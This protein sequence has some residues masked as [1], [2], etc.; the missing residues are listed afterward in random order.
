MVPIR[1]YIVGS[2]VTGKKEPRDLD[3]MAVMKN[4]DFE[5]IFG[6]SH[7]QF[8][9]EHRK[10]HSLK[11]TKWHHMNEGARLVLSQLYDKR[12]I[13]FKFACESMLYGR[14]KKITLEELTKLD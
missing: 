3:I 11:I 9:E 14:K 10:N 13:D 6:M 4:S 1:F 12:F 7:E 5:F 2:A 8:N